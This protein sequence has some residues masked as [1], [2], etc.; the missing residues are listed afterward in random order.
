VL[1]ALSGA[2]DES[3]L[4]DLSRF[5]PGSKKLARERLRGSGS[6]DDGAAEEEPLALGFRA[7]TRVSNSLGAPGA[8][9][10]PAVSQ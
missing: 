6:S 4:A 1:Q 8:S 7:H 9:R 2:G 3:R 5:L 10:E